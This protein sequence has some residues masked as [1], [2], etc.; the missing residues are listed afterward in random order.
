MLKSV[1]LLLGLVLAIGIVGEAA[2][3]NCPANSHASG[4]SGT[5][6]NCVCDSGYVYSGGA[7][8]RGN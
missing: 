2:A 4:N 6:V 5:T 1:S 3:Q 7:C 8:V